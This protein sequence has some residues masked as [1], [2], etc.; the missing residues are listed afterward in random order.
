MAGRKGQV[1]IRMPYPVNVKAVT[2]DHTSSLLVGQDMSSA[3]RSI[4]IIAYPPCSDCD[5]MGFEVSKAWEVTAVDYDVEG[6]T[7]Q[8]F[9]VPVPAA[10]C[11]EEVSS[12][13]AEPDP[14]GKMH[15]APPKDSYAAAITIA[16]EDNWGK[17]EYTC[18]YRFRV[19]G[20]AAQ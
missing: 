6:R 13:E 1:T 16:I 9:N 8:T 7:T 20:D 17:D 18:L 4:R 11:S 12:C 14:L 10:S 15:V 2:I 5:G 19:H 3:P